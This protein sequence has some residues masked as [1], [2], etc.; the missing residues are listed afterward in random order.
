MISVDIVLAN[1]PIEN[2]LSLNV[3]FSSFSFVDPNSNTTRSAYVSVTY[4]VC[5][6]FTCEK[7][8]HNFRTYRE[9]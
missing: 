9:F 8:L 1:Y 5:S 3:Y 6:T 4:K 2:H 7:F